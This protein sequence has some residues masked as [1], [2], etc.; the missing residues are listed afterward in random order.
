MAEW[1]MATEEENTCKKSTRKKTTKENT[2]STTKK[3]TRS[4]PCVAGMGSGRRTA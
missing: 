2:Q 3:A 4:V 1:L